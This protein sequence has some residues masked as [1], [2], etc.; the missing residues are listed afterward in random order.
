M[1][2]Y[3]SKLKCFHTEAKRKQQKKRDSVRKQTRDGWISHSRDGRVR[4][5]HSLTFITNSPAMIKSTEQYG[6]S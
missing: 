2:D 5:A 3:K 4:G 6:P 1:S